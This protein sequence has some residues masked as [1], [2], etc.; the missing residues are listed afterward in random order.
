MQHELLLLS[1][2]VA[3]P[4]DDGQPGTVP[5]RNPVRLRRV[6]LGS[7]IFDPRQESSAKVL[8]PARHLLDG[9]LSQMQVR[10]HEGKVLPFALFDPRSG[11]P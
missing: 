2:L 1:K 8:A 10:R 9:P 6:Y 7:K 5:R 4:Q 11:H 3:V